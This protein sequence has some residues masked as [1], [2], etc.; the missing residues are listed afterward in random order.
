MRNPKGIPFVERVLLSIG[1]VNREWF[2]DTPGLG[3]KNPYAG[4][5]S[6]IVYY[7]TRATMYTPLNTTLVNSHSD[8]MRGS[9]RSRSRLG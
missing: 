8:N 2:V 6:V 4:L 7:T 1:K 9:T 5:L 3:D